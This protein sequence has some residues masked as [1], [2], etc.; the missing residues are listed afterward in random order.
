MLVREQLCPVIGRVCMDQLML[1]IT[2]AKG[3]SVG[4]TVTVF[5]DG[6]GLCTA[7]RI[8]ENTGTINY[9]VVCAVGERVPRFFLQE[10]VP[11]DVSD[12]IWKR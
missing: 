11:V 2:D 10:G 9:E 5:G 8:A 1:D 7:D 4:D 3:I 12:N 6:G